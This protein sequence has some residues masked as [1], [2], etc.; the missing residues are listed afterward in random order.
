MNKLLDFPDQIRIRHVREALWRRGAGGAS[1]MIGSGFSRNAAMKAPGARKP[2]DWAGVANAMRAKLSPNPE[3][4]SR[5]AEGAC[6][7]DAL[8]TAQ[9]Y[10]DEFGRAELHRFLRDQ[11]RDD[12]MEPGDLHRRLLALPWADIFTTNW[13]TLLER[14]REMTIMPTYEV[15][16]VK[17]ELPLATR[18]RIVKLHGSLPAQFPLIATE[19][20]YSAYP[21]NFGPFVNTARQALMETVFLLLGF[22]GDDPNFL[23]WSEWVQKELGS[24]A[25]KI[26]LAG[27]LNLARDVREH[28]EET[29]VVPI[30][31]ARHP[32]Q[33]E[34]RRQQME[35]EFAMDWLLTTLEL[36]QPYPSEEWPKALAQPGASI[37]SHLEPV[38]RTVWI[39]PSVPAELQDDEESGGLGEA[40]IDEVVSAWAYNRELYPGWLALPEH[41]RREL[42]DPGI[43]D[44][45]GDLLDTSKEDRILQG[46]GDWSLVERLR[47]VHEIVW[48][49]EVRLEPLGAELAL[50]AKEILEEVAHNREAL[51]ERVL[52]RQA[53]CRIAM[54]SVTHARFGF[55]RSEFD[56][57]VRVATGFAQ[58][59]V[60]ALHGLQYEKCLW[61]LYENDIGSLVEALDAWRVDA[62]DPYWVVRKASLM[63]EADHGSEEVVPLLHS[64]VAALRRS[65]GYS[66]E[67]SVLSRESWAA[68]LARK[69]DERSW[70]DADGSNPH[71]ARARDLARF[72]CDPSSE[73]RA[74]INAVEWRAKREKGPGFELGEGPRP[75]GTLELTQDGVPSADSMGAQAS[76]RLVRL[77]EVVGLPSLSDR[78]PPTKAML[79][80]AGEW[81]HR[82]GDTEFAMRLML[83][84]T[85]YEDDDLVRR[86]LS[87]PNLA[88]APET[89][90]ASI[91]GLCE[92][93]IDY[94]SQRVPRRRGPKGV[95]S[96]IERV[97]VAMEMLA[98]LALRLKP[99]RA[100]AVL[101][102]GLALYGNPLFYNNILLRD[103][104]RHLLNRPWEALPI[105]A[106]ADLALELL[107]APIVGVDGYTPNPYGFIDP[108][109]L[110]DRGGEEA[111]LRRDEQNNEEWETTVRFLVRALECGEEARSRAMLRIVQVALAGRLTP[112]EEAKVGRAIWAKDDR[113]DEGL[114]GEKTLRHWVYLRMPEPRAGIA[115]E[116]FREKWMSAVDLSGVDGETLDKMLFHIGD[117]KERSQ[118]HELSFEFGEQDEDYVV[119]MLRKWADT[120]LP[121]LLIPGFDQERIEIIRNGIRGA[122]TLLMYVD[123]PEDVAEALYAK[124][125]KL[126][127]SGLPEMPLLVGLV[128][129]LECR[130]PEIQTALRKGFSSG[131]PQLVSNSAVAMQFWLDFAGRGM[132]R[133]PPLD[134]TREIGVIIATCRVD[135]LGAAL[136]VAEWVIS[137]GEE[138]DRDELRQLAVEG[139]GSL[140]DV[141]DYGRTFPQDVDVPFLR[142]RCVGL[143]RAMHERCCDEKAVMAWLAA[144]QNDPLPEVW[145][146]VSDIVV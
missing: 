39:A 110:I 16:R 50:A 37:R 86:L 72:N 53:V 19:Q 117:V 34:W 124:H 4:S 57:A 135:A 49:R 143:A 116:W 47:I 96:P 68:Y 77:A 97:R 67:I 112:E 142:W 82:D 99:E 64:A 55:D 141:L 22:S 144:A 5:S 88:T 146:K 78:W 89:V 20:D 79:A 8:A 25:P 101:R 104:I 70:G 45:S 58:H 84:V 63:F 13:D 120:P 51:E 62:G 33:E 48:R 105:P 98:R 32:K 2:P 46:M 59:D 136:W 23:R 11:I 115:E 21:S 42:R 44:I 95:V 40:K 132:V 71:R 106:K 119:A 3:E 60:N 69:L 122:A 85:T 145:Q 94:Y 65:R 38:D 134:L 129:A 26:Y 93:I 100:A 54:A 1:V 61:E 113:D 12:D 127:A 17:D 131:D 41:L 90:V 30:D 66:L 14:T 80:Q 24:S 27:W 123:V 10:S 56:E 125:R 139:L 128:R 74:L 52:D 108:G 109:Q 28:L 76:Y 91:V 140:I 31:L 18:P 83:R 87:R 107:A 9:Q 92:R 102:R 111:I 118:L 114:P 75:P 29:G 35:H 73:I 137:D 138:G 81:L 133:R 15:V 7:T 43:H 126:S 6:A 36:G 103:A 121:G 130:E